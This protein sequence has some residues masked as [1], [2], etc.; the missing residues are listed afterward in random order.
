MTILL[1]ENKNTTKTTPKIFMS[2]LF[3]FCYN[4]TYTKKK[5]IENGA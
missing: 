3:F 5:S 4:I 1:R 2:V